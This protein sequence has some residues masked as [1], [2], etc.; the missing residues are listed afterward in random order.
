MDLWSGV[1]KRLAGDSFLRFIRSEDIRGKKT[2]MQIISGEVI[3]ARNLFDPKKYP[4]GTLQTLLRVRAN[5]TEK[6]GPAGGQYNVLTPIAE[7]TFGQ[8]Y[9]RDDGHMALPFTLADLPQNTPLELTCDVSSDF[10]CD[11]K[12]GEKVLSKI[13]N[14]TVILS[15][16]NTPKMPEIALYEFIPR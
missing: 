14:G 1:L 11:K 8:I 7:A 4:E 2:D 6:Y 12:A 13:R 10:P 9:L 16:D 5:T 15:G 3:W